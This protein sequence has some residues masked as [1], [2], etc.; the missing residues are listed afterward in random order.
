[1]PEHSQNPLEKYFR[2]PAIYIKLPSQGRF[3][4]EKSINLPVNLEIPVYPMTAIDEITIRTPDA[5]LNGSGVVNIIQSCCPDII[6]AWSVPS[7]DIDT[8]LIGIRIASYGHEMDFESSCIHCKEK[9][10]HSVDLR[11]ILDS[12]GFPNFEKEFQFDNLTFKF[13][14][15]NYFQFNR[16]NQVSFEENQALKVINDDSLDD[17]TKT[18]KFNQHVQNIV[19]ISLGSL[20]ENTQSISFDDKTVTD[21]NFIR[22]FYEKTNSVTVKKVKAELE[23]LLE[24]S[25]IKNLSLVCDSC[26]KEYQTSFVFDYSSF[27]D[28]GF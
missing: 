11:A 24:I 20:A 23:K 15:Q 4:D 1:M 3:W 21:V 27:F 26:S 16:A 2:T 14:P 5:L 19:K 8:I 22:E 25:S 7:T 12:I 18:A 6:N 17:E 28:N 13:K 9:N 10:S